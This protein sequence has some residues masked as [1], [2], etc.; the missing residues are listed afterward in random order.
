LKQIISD[1]Y[2]ILWTEI[3]DKEFVKVQK[4]MIRYSYMTSY[5]TIKSTSKP[6][7]NSTDEIRNTF[8]RLYTSQWGNLVDSLLEGDAIKIF[9]Q[10]G[11][12]L[13][14]TM[15][16]TGQR[17]GIKYEFDI[18]AINGT[19]IVIIEVKTTLRPEDIRDFLKKLKMTKQWM[20]E[21]KDKIVYG[22]VAFISEDAGSSA[23]AEKKGLFVIKATGDS[24]S[25]I[26]SEV[27]IPKTW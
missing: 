2:E 15:R 21:Y 5:S 18:I 12:E 3:L 17:D 22:A 9:N 10:H 11:I 16:R 13:T 1:L 19:N 25:I 8:E 4:E 7:P 27:F 20:P 14:G 6:D 26:N 24:A 23:M